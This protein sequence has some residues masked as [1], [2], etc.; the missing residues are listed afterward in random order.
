ML[1]IMYIQ[2]AQKRWISDDANKCC[3][4]R[5]SFLGYPVQSPIRWIK[6]KLSLVYSQL[7]NKK[8]LLIV[9]KYKISR[10]VYMSW[11]K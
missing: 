4:K 7:T 1:F 10:V 3:K 9:Y 8:S 6:S 11:N 5:Q 2:V